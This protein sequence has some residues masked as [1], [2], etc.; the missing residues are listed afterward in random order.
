M[1][2]AILCKRAI[3][4]VNNSLL[5]PSN[6]I[7]ETEYTTYLTY[8]YIYSTNKERLYEVEALLPNKMRWYVQDIRYIIKEKENII[9]IDKLCF[10][11]SNNFI[12]F[13]NIIKDENKLREILIRRGNVETVYALVHNIIAYHGSINNTLLRLIMEIYKISMKDIADNLNNTWCGDSVVSYIKNLT[14]QV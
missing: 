8:Y 2:Y 9:N 6:D 11:I 7:S 10:L 3:K 4:S 12:I 13:I 14:S 5:P 1:N